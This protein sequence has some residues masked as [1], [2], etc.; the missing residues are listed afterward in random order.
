MASKKSSA[1]QRPRAHG[2][3]KGVTNQYMIAAA[4]AIVLLIV[5]VVVM[6]GGKKAP[7]VKRSTAAD[8][9]VVRRVSKPKSKSTKTLALDAKSAKRD[10][11][12]Q[13][14]EDRK[15]RTDAKQQARVQGRRTQRSQ[16]GGFTRGSGSSRGSAPNQLKMIVTDPSTNQRYAVVGDRRFKSGDD[17]EGRRIIEVGSDAVKI[18]YRQNQYSVR[19]GEQVY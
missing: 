2:V 5:V 3:K 10:R 8:T 18:E 15:R 4:V 1:P 19:V 14:A 6:T 12:A 13:A 16:S 7:A 17:I 9:G 11:R